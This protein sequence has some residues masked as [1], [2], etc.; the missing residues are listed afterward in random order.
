MRSRIP[1]LVFS[2]RS[3]SPKSGPDFVCEVV[4]E[5]L[6][7]A[8]EVRAEFA[9]RADIAG[10]ILQHE[11]RHA[12]YMFCP[13]AADAWLL[14]RA[15]SLGLYRKG[16]NQLLVHGVVLAEEHLEALE[17]NPLLLDLPAVQEGSGLIFRE[18]HPGSER[19][20]PPLSFDGGVA[21]LC[22]R[23]NQERLERIAELQEEPWLAA[24]YDVLAQGRRAGFA[25]PSPEPALLEAV[26]LH[27]HPDDRLELSFHTFYS[28]S[29]AVD[30]RLLA[31]ASE[32]AQVVRGQFRDLRLLELDERPPELPA[33]SLGYR[34]VRLRQRS[35]KT[36]Q[37]TLSGYRLTFWSHRF[38]NPLTGEDASLILRAGLGE[39]MTAKE[40]QRLQKL[41]GRGQ[42]GLRYRIT[43]LAGVWRDEPERF[44]QQ[45]DELGDI[46][47][48]ITQPK[49]AE[50]L[51]APP[52][53]LDERWCLLALLTRDAGLLRGVDWRLERK[54]AWRTLMQPEEL[55]A[56]LDALNSVQTAAGEAILREY[57]LESLQPAAGKLP[58]P[59]YWETFCAWLVRRGRL[60]SKLLEHFETKVA[61]L[62][63]TVAQEAW[64]RLQVLA[65]QAGLAGEALRLLFSRIL[66]TLSPADAAE[67]TKAAI[68]WWLAKGTEHDAAV[69]PLLGRLE[70]AR[71]ALPILGDWLVEEDRGEQTYSRLIR[72]LDGLE[73]LSFKAGPA[74]GQLLERLA[75]TRFGDRVPTVL[76]RCLKA[77]SDRE[78]NRRGE[79]VGAA[80]GHA[81][82]SLIPV[83]EA[84]CRV[85][86]LVLYIR[87]VASLLEARNGQPA[88]AAAD[89]EVLHL[90]VRGRILAEEARARKLDKD[91]TEPLRQPWLAFLRETR[92]LEF[93]LA[94]GASSSAENLTRVEEWL[95]LLQ[96]EIAAD[97]PRDAEEDPRFKLFI[98]LAW[99]RWV[100]GGDSI[101]KLAVCAKLRVATARGQIPASAKWLRQQI[102]ER[103]PRQLWDE[104]LRL[105]PQ[106]EPWLLG[107]LKAVWR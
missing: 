96:D 31:V 6:G 3:P 54:K 15:V 69:A 76:H 104:A 85:R 46:K 98:R 93:L 82:T 73:D 17:G 83:L 95:N 79:F 30:Y 50:I 60:E 51:D 90:A 41:A 33:E 8:D 74:C 62:G 58:R 91:E 57:V 52:T 92:V 1:Q 87:A 20:L 80:L 97:L 36:F 9:R 75:L 66:P 64:P 18:E 34:A 63:G 101:G 53:S 2:T 22:H 28:H 32:D 48:P 14:C 68:R 27:F 67:K 40:R 78:E 25:M 105:L 47:D 12:V 23:L 11:L 86:D 59:P 37:E 5:S 100:V 61:Q 39:A 13:V 56:F 10:S 21:D 16:S 7:I 45:L 103:V 94:P 70:V 107:K 49:L 89:A 65:F 71:H 42:H 24:A 81:A 77:L 44:T 102:E 29:R 99:W 106:T 38:E 72:I 55:P 26:L 35:V 84:P 19:D 4:A 43:T 88:T